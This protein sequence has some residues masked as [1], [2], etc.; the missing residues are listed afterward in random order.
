M[1]EEDVCRMQLFMSNPAA[2]ESLM[3]QAVNTF[4]LGG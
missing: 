2:A 3:L 4:L 1:G